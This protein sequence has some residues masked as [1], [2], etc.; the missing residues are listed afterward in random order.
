MANIYIN[1]Y[2]GSSG[3]YIDSE[4]A[5]DQESLDKLLDNLPADIF[6]AADSLGWTYQYWQTEK[7]DTVNES[8]DKIGADELPAVTQLFT[9]HYMVLFLYHNTIGAWH[10]GKVLAANPSLAETAQS[11]EELRQAVRLQSEGG[12]D[13]EY[14]RFVREEKEGDEEDT[15]T[16][17]WRD[18][19]DQG[20]G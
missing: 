10:A 15:P 5:D 20:P 19:A 16:G 14:L 2:G 12:Y 11:E 17:P 13:F 3:L 1:P 18:E 9:E 8:G 6:T 4:D 7:K